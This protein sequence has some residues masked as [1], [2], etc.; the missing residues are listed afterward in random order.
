MMAIDKAD[1]AVEKASIDE[2]FL[3]LSKPIGRLL[4]ILSTEDKHWTKLFSRLMINDGELIAKTTIGGLE[5]PS[6]VQTNRLSKDEIRKGSYLQVIE[7][8]NSKH[9]DSAEQAWWKRGRGC[10][11]SDIGWTI[12]EL[13]L[14]MGLGSHSR[15]GRH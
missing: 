4:E 12:Q 3:D 9:S 7:H 8:V 11:L 2:V 13:S 14:A 6:D 1:I 15:Q 10:S 5:N